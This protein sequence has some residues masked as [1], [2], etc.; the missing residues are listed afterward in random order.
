MKVGLYARVSTEN[1]ELESQEEKLVNWAERESHDYDLYSEK[2]SSVDERPEFENLMDKLEKYDAVVVTRLDRFARSIVDFH[3][4]LESLED[5][6]ADF[7]T[8]DQPFDTMDDMYGEFMMNMTV[9]FA[10]FERKMI[11]RRMKEGFEKA[12]EEER[13]G[14][15]SKL[16]EKH[17]EFAKNVYEQ[18]KSVAVVK[19]RVNNKFE[20]GA[21]YSAVRRALIRQEAGHYGS[22]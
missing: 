17:E 3:D 19:D 21:S 14:R 2:V 18:G 6:N 7:I 10:E 20:L 11:R 8:T 5:E 22:A 13:V 16:D 12:K 9:S 1:Q 15:P 4:R